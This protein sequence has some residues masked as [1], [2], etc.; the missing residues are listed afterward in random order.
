MIGIVNNTQTWDDYMKHV[1][2]S[3]QNITGDLVKNTGELLKQAGFSIATSS[4]MEHNW[5]G[6]AGGLTLAAAGGFASG[7]GNSLVNYKN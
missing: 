2:Q 1:G 5:L 7:L 3:A 6:V 4:A